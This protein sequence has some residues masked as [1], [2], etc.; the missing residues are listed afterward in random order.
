MGVRKGRPGR[1]EEWTKEENLL[2]IQGWAR[3][4][5][6]DKDIAYNIG[7]HVGTLYEWK[8]KYP[9][10][11]E[12]LRL[13]KEVADRKVENSL[14]QTAIGF[15]YTEEAVTNK[16]TVVSVKKKYLPNVTAQIFW[17]KNRKPGEWRDKKE[18][19]AKID[20]QYVAV[21]GDHETH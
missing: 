21:W 10:L 9:R 16:G 12:A 6:T 19:E 1:G 7:I 14:F 18:M 4:G 5:L 17:L 13:G 3:D 8:K 2:L 20:H 11:T 15:E